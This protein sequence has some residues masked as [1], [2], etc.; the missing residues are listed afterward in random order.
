MKLKDLSFSRSR[1]QKKFTA[2]TR[3]RCWI[4][5]ASISGGKTPGT[6]PY[7]NFG[8]KHLGKNKV[9]LAHRLAF[10]LATGKVRDDRM[11]C[12]TCNHSLCVNPAHLYEGTALDNGRDQ[13]KR[14]RPGWNARFTPA[15]VRMI[16]RMYLLG[17]SS[18]TLAKIYGVK[19]WSMYRLLTGA[20]YRYVPGRVNMRRLR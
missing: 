15:Q 14:N 11:V 8:V 13:R 10:I 18:H 2:S 3:D 7:G 16:R 12:H 17:S 20:T 19:Q 6:L 4:W 5:H 9:V 1:F